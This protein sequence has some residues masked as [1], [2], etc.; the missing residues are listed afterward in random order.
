MKFKRVKS[1]VLPMG[2][3][4]LRNPARKKMAQ[5]TFGGLGE[6]HELA[7]KAMVS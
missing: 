3:D 7:K 6:H 5:I 1:Q 4:D 2:R